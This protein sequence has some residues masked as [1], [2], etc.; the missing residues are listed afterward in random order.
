MFRTVLKCSHSLLLI[1]IVAVGAT[2]QTLDRQIS[3]ASDRYPLSKPVSLSVSPSGS[4]F[5]VADQFADRIFVFDGDGNLRWLVGDL[6][7][8]KQPSAVCLTSDEELLFTLK[9]SLL[10]LKATSI[11]LQKLDTLADLSTPAEK[12]KSVDRLV[13]SGDS[14]FVILDKSSAKACVF[15][16]D[17]KFRHIL[18]SS[19]QGRGK[20][21][22]PTDLVVDVSGNVIF[23]DERNYSIQAVSSSGAFLFFSGWNR[24]GTERSWEASTVGVDLQGR[25]WAADYVNTQWRL[26]DRSGNEIERRRFDPSEYHPIC[27]AFTPSGKMI[28]VDERGI[29]LLFTVS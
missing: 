8:I 18:V 26:F 14:S 29:I 10:V 28:V 16:A 2:A 24:P 6:I 5:A 1:A 4:Y 17:W 25:I 13:R 11:D 3:R 21:W 22:S 12:L 9:N 7:P 19:G 23:S 27:L 20:V 15:G